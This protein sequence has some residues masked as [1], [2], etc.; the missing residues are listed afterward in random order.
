[1]E[2]TDSAFDVIGLILVLALFTPILISCTLPFL[3]GEVG[4]F[5]VQ[6]EKTA[7]T[8]EDVIVPRNPRPTSA[9]D[10]LLMLVVAD[11]NSPMPRM[12]DIN[13]LQL[14][15]DE[16]FYT[17][18]AYQVEQVRQLLPSG[19]EVDIRLYGNSTELAYWQ[20]R[21]ITP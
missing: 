12:L 11:R 21:T 5:Q 17:N 6:I 7:R 8:T 1:M 19:G 10:F 2:E 9:N 4:G 13:G 16:A 15:M 3:R 18:K 20:V 14:E